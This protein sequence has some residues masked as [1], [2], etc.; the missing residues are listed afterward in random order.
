MELQ[1]SFP[2]KDMFIQLFD[3]NVY[4]VGGYVRDSL[5]E[6]AKDEGI[7]LLISRHPVDAIVDKLKPLGKV[8][9]VGKSFG[10]I[11]FTIQGRTYD[12]VLPRTDH[13]KPTKI[14][15]HKDFTI[16]ADPNLPIE[17]D[18]VRRDFR[19]N[20]IAL[21]LTDGRIIDPL[22][23][24]SDI[25]NK[26]LRVT[27]PQSFPEDPLRVL[28]AARFASVLGFKVDPDLYKVAKGIDVSGLSA[29][30]VNEELFRILLE[31]PAPSIGLEELF[32]LDT[33]RQLL[34]ALYRL[35]LTIQDSIFHPEKDQYGHHTVWKHTK[36]TVDQAKRLADKKGMDEPRKLALLLAALYHDSG[37]VTTTQWEFK[38]GRM[39]IITHGHDIT[40]EKITEDVFNR[41]KIYSWKGYDLRKTALALIKCHHRASELWQ[42]RE[43]LTKKAF[44]RLNADMNGE[45]ELLVYLDVADRAGRSETPV[46][47]LDNQG[48][49]LLDKYEELKISK[50]NLKPI[51]LGRDLIDKGISPGP[52]M[53]QIL[54]RLY[55]LQLDNEFET[56][57]KGLKLADQIIQE[58]AEEEH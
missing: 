37:K 43:V 51:I 28:R 39:V 34:P 45:I 10:V 47:S 5:L 50:D 44:N 11:K 1:V 9:L 48:Q 57:E 29:E 30:R 19:C 2:E 8:D 18:L 38:K 17:E 31:S 13:P 52:Q 7:D 55:Q 4:I 25:Q 26:I 12:I 15:G 24:V 54:D 46:D 16:A 42:N 6:R 14:R 41:F 32:V 35:T 36:I 56:K 27:N 53:G 49:W 21:R 22:D 40:G 58:L 3:G 33:L 20:S 23:G